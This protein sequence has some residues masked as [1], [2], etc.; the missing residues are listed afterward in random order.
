MIPRIVAAEVADDRDLSPKLRMEK[1]C[2][3][4]TGDR[5]AELLADLV[6]AMLMLL[7]CAWIGLWTLVT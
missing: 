6:F 7:L 5:A 4:I 1:R 3:L 2:P